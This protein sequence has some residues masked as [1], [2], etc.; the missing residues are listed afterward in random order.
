M[1]QLTER[2]REILDFI[3]GFGR[4]N[5]YPPTRQEIMQ[6][7]SFASPTAVTGHLAALEKK[8]YLQ[9][10]ER[11]SRGL[12]VRE[13]TAEWASIPVLGRVPA[14]KPLAEEEHAE[15]YLLLDRKFTGSGK[16]FSLK[17]KG[18]SM[19]GAGI[20]SGDYVLV[21]KEMA[22]QNGDIVVAL[23]DGEFTVKFFHRKKNCIELKPAHPGFKTIKVKDNLQIAGK[24]TGLFRKMP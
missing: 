8:G 19:Q 10:R 2:Q 5:G 22:V 11:I 6:N 7:F 18:E 20:L 23:T 14:G 1:E 15:D 24:V 21:D 16:V 12:V 13:K 3:R 17:V 9:K 4:K